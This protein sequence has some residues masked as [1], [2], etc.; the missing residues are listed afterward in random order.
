MAA[1]T[2]AARIGAIEEGK[3][4]N[5]PVYFGGADNAEPTEEQIADPPPC[6]YEL[7]KDQIGGL[8]R[9]FALLGIGRSGSYVTMA[10]QV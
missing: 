8:N 1:I 4:R 2:R 3:R 5:E 10:L 9:A 7:A 6:G